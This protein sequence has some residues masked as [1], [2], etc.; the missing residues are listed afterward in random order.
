MNRIAFVLLCIFV[1][2]CVFWFLSRSESDKPAP[3]VE[4]LR[5]VPQGFKEYKS[6][7]Y[8]FSL[9]YPET[10]SVR[11]EEDSAT[12]RSIIFEDPETEAGFQ[13]FIVYYPENTISEERFALDVPSGVR[14]Q[15]EMTTIDGVPAVQFFSTH[16]DVGETREVWCIHN[17]Y[18]FE[19]TT[20]KPLSADVETILASW[21]WRR[22]AQ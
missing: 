3:S 19:I 12:S 11:E 13:I 18:L 10:L 21:Q 20:Y 15:E 7:R 5:E 9:L 17:N 4:V 16:P 6:G 14:E 22:G 2:L 8:G 1:V